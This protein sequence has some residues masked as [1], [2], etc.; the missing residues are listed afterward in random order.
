MTKIKINR[1]VNLIRR[2]KELAE[3]R[4]KEMSRINSRK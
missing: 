3:V 4:S 2:A 1:S